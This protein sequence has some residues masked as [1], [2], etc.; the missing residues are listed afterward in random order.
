MTK[1]SETKRLNE[2]IG[3]IRIDVDDAV[4]FVHGEFQDAFAKADRYY[5][6]QV[7]LPHEI[8]R[9]GVVSTQVRDAIRN[10]RPSIM[11]VLCSNRT[12]LVRYRP[13]NIQLAAVVDQQTAYVHQIFWENNGYL[14]LFSA[15][16]ESLRHRFGAVKTYWEVNPTPLFTRVTMASEEEV[17]GISQMPGVTILSKKVS[18][19]VPGVSL[20][21]GTVLY[22]LECVQQKNNGSIRMDAV[23][24]G[25]FFISR[26]ATGTHDAR[27]H[28]HRR[29][30][31]VAEAMS[32]G[33]ECDHWE[34]LD[35]LDPIMDEVAQ[36]ADAKRRWSLNGE[37]DRGDL[38]SRRFLL[39]EA[40]IYADLNKTGSM[41]LYCLHLG[42][43]NYE[44]LGY[45][46]VNESPFDLLVHDINSFSPMGYSVADTLSQ[47]QDVI[48]SLLRGMVDNVHA[49]NHPRIAGNTSQVN[50]D[51]L[52]NHNIGYPIRM[53]GNNAQV[54]VVSVPNQIQAALPMLTWLEQD[55]QNKVGVTK[56]SQG[57]DPNAMQSTDKD[58]V[59]NTI[60]LGQG[61]VELAVRNI[62]ET[63]LIPIFKKLLRLSIAHKDRMQIVHTRGRYVPVDLLMFD[64]S[65]YAQ[66]EVGL[67]TATQ[68]TQMMGLQATFSMQKEMMGMLGVNNP[69]VSLS[70]IYNTIEDIVKG[71]GLDNVGRYFNLVDP[72]VEAQFSQMKA[73]EAA[74]QAQ[75]AKPL[76]PGIAMVKIEQ[77]KAETDKITKLVDARTDALRLK[78]SALEANA[79]DDFRRDKLA[80]DLVIAAAERY[81]RTG[82][83]IDMEALKREQTAART[84]V[85]SVAAEVKAPTAPG[86]M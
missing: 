1:A 55:A 10:L 51:D 2:I 13:S 23:P 77:I 69:M 32:L 81:G 61:Q 19:P 21:L 74:K 57:L 67:G 29:S 27:A 79:D 49:S 16:D 76:D 78:L 7:D 14:T 47:S 85:T 60:M 9:S 86:M 80:Q 11:R 62:I 84:P 8:G 18:A 56:A 22:D 20:P 50:F 36:Q 40:Y 37:V 41:Q 68:E 3:Q 33:I 71:F 75:E 52:L 39:T 4:S 42:G 12:R 54:Q 5:N 30:V 43:T 35:D 44:L 82:H 34:K 83:V 63:G 26:D 17:A 48:T 66:P 15:V 59:K 46:R 58:A 72:Q 38:L 25:E 64:P 6:G 45:Y 24:Y 65:L 53:K 73:Q 28:G 31:M 70:N